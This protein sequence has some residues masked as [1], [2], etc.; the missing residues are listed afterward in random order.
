[1]TSE[2][3][4]TALRRTIAAAFEAGG[5]TFTVTKDVGVFLCRRP[6]ARIEA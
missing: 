5:G 1:L 2:A 6:R 3:E 4:I